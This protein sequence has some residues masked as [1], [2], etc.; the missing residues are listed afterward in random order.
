MYF[1]EYKMIRL[2]LMH[3]CKNTFFLVDEWQHELV[4]TKK[5]FVRT[6]C[7]LPE[8]KFV[9]GV[10]FLKKSEDA[11]L[12]MRIFDRDGSEEN[13]CGN[14]IR[15]IAK[16]FFDKYGIAQCASVKTIDGTK[17]VKK[18]DDIIEVKMG[19]PREFKKIKSN[20]FVFTGCPHLVSINSGYNLSDI[21]HINNI[22]R[23]LSHDLNICSSLD[24]STKEGI[25]VN[26]VDSNPSSNKIVTYERHLEKCTLACGTG[27][28][29]AG[30]VL[31]KV[32]GIVFPIKLKNYGGILE[33]DMD[34]NNMILRG[35]AEYI[36]T[37][38]FND[39]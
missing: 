35:P 29:A 10:L 5:D 27:N 23:K 11:D 17:D 9:D 8:W 34:S 16:Y 26:F 39:K 18:I 2:T 24:I 38:F 22:G 21:R 4:F 37:I 7:N 12:E 14:G 15:C 31:H 28:T 19:P 36:K 3:G 20:Y 25:Y 33:V 6:V 32:L 13:M 30:Y 1:L